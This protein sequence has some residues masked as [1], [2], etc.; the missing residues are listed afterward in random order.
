MRSRSSW[1]SLLVLAAVCL[2]PASV[3]AAD[4]MV[5]GKGVRVRDF[6]D[7]D[8][9]SLSNARRPVFV[10][11]DGLAEFGDLVDVAHAPPLVIRVQGDVD[12]QRLPDGSLRFTL[13]RDDE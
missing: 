2:G 11:V 6:R 7:L 9:R 8:G 10:T 4:A 1:V 13:R 5:S 3:S 12:I